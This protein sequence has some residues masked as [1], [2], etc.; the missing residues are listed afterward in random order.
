MLLTNDEKSKKIRE[1]VKE[2]FER[3]RA[4]STSG[5]WDSMFRIIEETRKNKF[6]IDEATKEEAVPQVLPKEI[7][8]IHPRKNNMAD[9]YHESIRESNQPRQLKGAE[10][11]VLMDEEMRK[12]REENNLLWDAIVRLLKLI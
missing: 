8:G 4:R 11:R 1:R 5:D 2:A 7:S 9:A 10:K 12:L 6:G 3:R